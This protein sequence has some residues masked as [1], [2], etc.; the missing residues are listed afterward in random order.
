MSLNQDLI[1]NSAIAAAREDSASEVAST[2]L[3]HAVNVW[4]RE[5]DLTGETL[6]GVVNDVLRYATTTINEVRFGRGGV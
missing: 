1:S 5:H 6:S 3:R 2:F 4:A